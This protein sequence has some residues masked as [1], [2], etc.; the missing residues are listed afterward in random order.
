M[1]NA[2]GFTL[3]EVM[4]VVAIVA[5]LAA[6]AL[7]SYS[8]HTR[9]AK[10]IEATSQLADFRV[11]MEQFFLDNRTYRNAANACGVAA[12]TAPA[13]KYFTYVCNAPS[14]T[15][16]TVTASGAGEMDGLKYS[17][18]EQNVR[19]TTDVPAGWA[20]WTKKTDCWVLKKGG[21]C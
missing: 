9:R 16:Y 8:E 15:Q 4:I 19:A 10:I 5:I 7:P 18:N 13:V 14:A 17:I 20:G 6:V 3:I 11:R 2:K 12:P 1:T 21:A